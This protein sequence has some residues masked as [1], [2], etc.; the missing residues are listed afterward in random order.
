MFPGI[1]TQDVR[2]GDTITLYAVGCGPAVGVNPGFLVQGASQLSLP[3]EI[4]IGGK[5]AGLTYA[6]YTPGAIGLA[7][8]NLVIP[9]LAPGDYA[10]ELTVDGIPGEQGLVISIGPSPAPKILQIDDG[11]FERKLGLAGTEVAFVNRL[12]PAAYPTTLR[13]VRIYFHGDSDQVPVNHNVVILSGSNPGG[14]A[15]I[16]PPGVQMR[17]GTSQVVA[18]DRTIE[19]EITPLTI[20]S[21][22]FVVGFAITGPQGTFPMANDTSSPYQGRS[23]LSLDGGTTFRL[24]DTFAGVTP[25]NFI[26][27]AVVE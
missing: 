2:S 15:N 9:D 3:H 23:Y 26:I 17:R 16:D 10:I 25:G 22:D 19:Y 7:Q 14:T 6:G 5:K 20:N 8:F 27:R 1:P 21:G 13:A 18:I 4:R 24:V 12:T 11:S